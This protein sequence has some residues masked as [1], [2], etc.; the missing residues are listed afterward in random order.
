MEALTKQIVTHWVQRGFVDESQAEW[1]VYGLLC[2]IT[3]VCTFCVVITVGTL[4]SDVRY[5]LLFSLA[6]MYLRT[7]TNGHHAKTYVR[8]LINSIAIEVMAVTLAQYLSLSSSLPL[9]VVSSFVIFLKAPVND[10]NMHYTNEEIFAVRQKCR[11]RLYILL[12]FYF[13]TLLSVPFCSYCI[14]LAFAAD[15]ILLLLARRESGY[16]S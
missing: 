16:K 3:T 1:C 8:C 11:I 10:A 9:A 12:I 2:R 15:A 14:S 13:V 7:Y 4:V 5:A 6:F